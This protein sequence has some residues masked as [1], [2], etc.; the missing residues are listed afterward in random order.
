MRRDA[1]GRAEMETVVD[2]YLP[3]T[4][5]AQVLKAV[6]SVKS[7]MRHRPFRESRRDPTDWR[8]WRQTPAFVGDV[9]GH[10]D[11][12][13]HAM[14]VTGILPRG[15]LEVVTVDRLREALVG[16]LSELDHIQEALADGRVAAR[17]VPRRKVSPLTGAMWD[18]VLDERADAAATDADSAEV[19]A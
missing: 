8:S 17:S 15:R 16:R 4:P 18:Q 11:D 7:P 12:P 3:R 2:C 6:R 9:V 13:R 19:S 5:G 10:V 14:F 1:R